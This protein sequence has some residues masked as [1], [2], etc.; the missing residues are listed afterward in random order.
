MERH[1]TILGAFHIAFGAL[2]L[3]AALA[4]LVIFG[5]VA[6]LIGL[7]AASDP[8]ALLAVP[9]IGLI[10]TILMLAAVTLSLPGIAAGFGLMNYR[11]WARML[12]VVLS[13]L[14][15]FNF[16]FGSAL[17]AYGLWVL[18]S[19]E[20]RLLFERRAAAG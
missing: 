2:G 14:H 3:L 1:V 18:L 6:G 5:G 13:L 11:P 20:G 17:G 7:G 16:P 15:L 19:E 12:T 9:I 4:I 10:G 8:D